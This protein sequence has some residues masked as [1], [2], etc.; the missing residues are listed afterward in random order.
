MENM[1]YYLD[2]QDAYIEKMKK[3]MINIKTNRISM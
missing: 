3:I 1:R 2:I